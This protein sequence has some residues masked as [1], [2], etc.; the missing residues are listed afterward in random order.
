[1]VV[2]DDL[3]IQQHNMCVCLSFLMLNKDECK[4][5][6]QGK[7]EKHICE[8]LRLLNGELDQP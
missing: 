5:F 7:Y 3:G 8:A 2:S 4:G 1:M 6:K